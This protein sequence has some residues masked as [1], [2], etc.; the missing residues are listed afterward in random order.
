[1]LETDMWNVKVGSQRL[2]ATQNQLAELTPKCMAVL[3]LRP[4]TLMIFQVQG[5]C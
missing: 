3:T 2:A 5:N 1:M 4:V